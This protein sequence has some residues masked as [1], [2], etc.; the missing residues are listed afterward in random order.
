[1]EKRLEIGGT[2]LGF[3]FQRKA[4]KKAYENK[5]AIARAHTCSG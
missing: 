2:W 5:G 3:M 4:Q 1:V